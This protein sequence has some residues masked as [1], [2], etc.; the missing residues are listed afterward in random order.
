MLP[1]WQGLWS[2]GGR[3]RP[4]PAGRPSPHLR[5]RGIFGLK[6]ASDEEDT[7]RTSIEMLAWKAGKTTLGGYKQNLTTADPDP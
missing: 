6:S 1:A 3:P 4:G 5:P 2:V 7:R